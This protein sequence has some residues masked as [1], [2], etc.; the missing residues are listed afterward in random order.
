M[1]EISRYP[2]RLARLWSHRLEPEQ[3]MPREALHLALKL[4]RTPDASA[5]LL[6]FAWTL[7]EDMYAH[8]GWDIPT[9]PELARCRNAA[10][11]S[12]HNCRLAA[13]EMVNE[14]QSRHGPVSVFSALTFSEAL[15]GRWDI[16]PPVSTVIVPLEDTAAEPMSATSL[17]AGRGIWHASPGRLHD[18]LA[19]GPPSEAFPP[20]LLPTPALILAMTAR[21]ALA[22]DDTSAL[23]FCAALRAC[24]KLDAWDHAWQIANLAGV[25]DHVIMA[26]RKHRATLPVRQRASLRFRL[27]SLLTDVVHR[28]P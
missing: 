23:F 19:A 26:A 5:A 22:G 9:E 10:Q 2:V 8:L 20:V 11:S 15:F 28:Q 4:S 12:A 14:L 13:E 21:P 27:G 1:S 6:S 7:L 16:I 25:R 3:N 24:S 17:R 18:E